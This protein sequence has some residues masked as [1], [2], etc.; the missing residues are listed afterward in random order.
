L[1][2]A[3]RALFPENI[4]EHLGIPTNYKLLF[5]IS[6]GYEDRDIKANAA[7][8][9]RAPVDDVVQFHR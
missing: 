2:P 3:R 9:G 8:V 5:G 1:R 6:F 4:R 7:R